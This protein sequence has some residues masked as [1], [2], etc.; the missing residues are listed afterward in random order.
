MADEAFAVLHVLCSFTRREIDSVHVHGIRVTG[1]SGGSSILGQQ[2]ITVSPTSE[3]PK[4]YHILVEL[5]C[6]VEPLFPFPAN[7]FLSIRESCSSHHD[8]KLIVLHL[9]WVGMNVDSKG[10]SGFLMNT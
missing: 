1:R 5:P 6:L 7:L 4:L 10:C 3:C 9:A 2:N 8:S